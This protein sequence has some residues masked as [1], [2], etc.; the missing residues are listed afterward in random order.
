MG[1]V[2]P[3]CEAGHR[4]KHSNVGQV[5]KPR[6]FGSLSLSF[7]LSIYQRMQNGYLTNNEFA[8]P[9]SSLSVVGNSS[10]KNRG[11]CSCVGRVLAKSSNLDGK[12]WMHLQAISCLDFTNLTPTIWPQR[13]LILMTM[14]HPALLTP[15]AQQEYGHSHRSKA[16]RIAD[17]VDIWMQ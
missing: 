9:F 17:W 11:F 14:L 2:S 13:W 5:K 16:W 15:C 3:Q 8:P 7:S 10:N 1:L 4:Q 12:M 6:F